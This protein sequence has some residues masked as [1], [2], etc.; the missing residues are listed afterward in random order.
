MWRN[1]FARD[2]LPRNDHQSIKC[3]SIIRRFND[4][5]NLLR[6]ILNNNL[7]C[8]AMYAIIDIVMRDE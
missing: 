8:M 1:N 5:R 7:L 6:L 3:N 2:M 4:L